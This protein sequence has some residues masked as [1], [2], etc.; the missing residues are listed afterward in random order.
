MIDQWKSVYLPKEGLSLK[1]NLPGP[2]I[3]S[4]ALLSPLPLKPDFSIFKANIEK[5]YFFTVMLLP[6]FC[7]K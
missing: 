2:R 3:K 4:E 7:S 1:E 5:N 6:N